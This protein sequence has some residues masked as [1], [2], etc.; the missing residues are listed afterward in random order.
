M[1]ENRSFDH[2]LGWL[3]GADGRQAGLA[4]TDKQGSAQPT[5]P[6]APNFQN[7]QFDDPGSLVRGRSHAVQRR[8]QRRLAA[9]R[10]Q[11]RLPDRLLHAGRSGLLRRRGAGVD[12]LRSLLRR[13][14]RPDVPEPL[15]PARGADRPPDQHARPISILPT[16]WDRLADDGLSGRYYYS[17]LP[18]T[19]ALW[20]AST[21]RSP[22]RS[23]QFFADAAA[24]TL[25]N[26][27][28]VDPRF[29]GEDDGHRRTTIIRSP[30]S[31]TARRS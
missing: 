15:L 30:T 9:R 29:V 12:D 5:F 21:R 20:A 22:S 26:V 7:C 3:P 11:R 17:D 19:G 25:P 28:F 1:M 23:T 2:F 14:P 4:F 6:L 18:V 8:R 16:I 24:G 27:S 13:D 31:A 10:H